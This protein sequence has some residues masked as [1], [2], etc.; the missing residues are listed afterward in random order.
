MTKRRK[1]IKTASLIVAGAG[2]F[3]YQASQAKHIRSFVDKDKKTMIQ[4]NVFF[5][6]KEGVSKSDKKGFEKGMV[7]FLS[8]VKEIQ[9]FEIG[10]PAATE[11]RDVVDH[12]FEYALFVWFKTIDDHNIYQKHPAHEVFI[13]NFSSLWEKVQVY[14]VDLI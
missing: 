1:F 8:S 13:N 10:I 5:W 6:V 11:E 12:S 3:G 4:H 14:D 7:E 9:K 2:T